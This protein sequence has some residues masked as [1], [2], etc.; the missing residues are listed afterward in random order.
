MTQYVTDKA[1]WL[2]ADKSKVV[3]AGDPAAAFL[4]TPKGHEVDAETAARYGLGAKKVK[5]EDKAVRGP[6]E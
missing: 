6:K 3:E 1:L 4:L 5:A 2:N